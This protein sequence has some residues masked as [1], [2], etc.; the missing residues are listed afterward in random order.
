M[1]GAG[2]VMERGFAVVVGGVENLWIAIEFGAE[3]VFRAL[4]RLG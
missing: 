3:A 1:A 4:Q 2:G